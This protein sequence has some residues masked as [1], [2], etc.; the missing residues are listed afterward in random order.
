[1]L[2][3]DAA[4]G[5]GRHGL[6]KITPESNTATASDTLINRAHRQFENRIICMETL[7]CSGSYR[8]NAHPLATLSTIDGG[9]TSKARVP[10]MPVADDNA[11]T[12][13]DGT[14]TC[15]AII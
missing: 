11:R 9:F 12:V 7:V 4:M 14:S 3:L 8:S 13:P 15:R 2:E 1:M 6:N 10:L 5:K